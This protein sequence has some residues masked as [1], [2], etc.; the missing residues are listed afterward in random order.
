MI[1]KTATWNKLLEAAPAGSVLMG[2]AIRDWTLDREAKDYDIFY[3]YYIPGILEIPDWKYIPN[4]D[5]E[6][7]QAEYDIGAGID[8]Q[9]NP[10]AIVSDYE[11]PIG[12]Y[13]LTPDGL[14][15]PAT[16][17]VQLIGVHYD[18]PTE[19]FKNFDHTLTL[20]MYGKYGLCIDKRMF[21]SFHNKT[22]TCTNSAKPEKSLARAQSVVKRLWGEQHWNYLGF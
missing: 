22:V 18:D 14:V 11:V 16:V 2:G 3:P 20:G 7:H 8:N 4:P 1:N 19:H 12:S 15:I 10:I 5:A 6:A 13:A 17:K 9:L 21:D